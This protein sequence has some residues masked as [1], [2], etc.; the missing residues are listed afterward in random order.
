MQKWKM[1]LNNIGNGKTTNLIIQGLF[2]GSN[3]E[4]KGQYYL[5]EKPFKFRPLFF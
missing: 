5:T 4:D 1:N 3:E 2:E